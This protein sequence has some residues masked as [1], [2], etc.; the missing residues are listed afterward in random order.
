MPSDAIKTVARMWGSVITR[1]ETS[2]FS[3]R[4]TFCRNALHMVQNSGN[5]IDLKQVVD[6]LHD[7]GQ[8]LQTHAGINVGSGQRLIVAPCRQHR[9]G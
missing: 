7:T 4:R 1:M 6:I 9:T 8:T 2:S 3:S 5:G